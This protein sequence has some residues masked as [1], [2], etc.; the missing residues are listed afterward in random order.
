MSLRTFANL[1]YEMRVKKAKKIADLLTR[2]TQLRNKR[3]LDIGTGAGVCADFFANQV[4]GPHGSV[5]AVDRSDQR[6]VTGQ[7]HFEVVEGVKLPFENK[8]IDIVISNHV[9]EHV[10]GFND[11]ST[12][13][14][15]I[16][17]VLKSGGILYLAFPNRFA[18]I[19]PHFKL[20]FLSWL[21]QWFADFYVKGTG[22]GECFD[23]YTPSRWEF[24]QL[25][26]ETDLNKTEITEEVFTY[27]VENELVGNRQLV[28]KL[29]SPFLLPLFMPIMPTLVHILTKK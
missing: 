13:L 25:L 19:E 1:E 21:P 23:C 5:V 15:E 6:L 12:H 20:P 7:Y 24:E 18:V 9:I 4:V 2:K 17:R 22:K 14:K 8:S 28:A 11:K 29:L 26:K 16:S 3:V 10:G 27:V